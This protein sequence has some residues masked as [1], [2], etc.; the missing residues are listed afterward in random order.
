M[1]KQAGYPDIKCYPGSW[2]EWG[3]ED[4]TPVIQDEDP[5]AYDDDDDI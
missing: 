2:S 4:D 3:N 1:L 5:F